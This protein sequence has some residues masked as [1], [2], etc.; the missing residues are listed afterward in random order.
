M[1]RGQVTHPR[2]V[3]R[4]QVFVSEAAERDIAESFKWYRA[5]SAAAAEVFRSEVIAAIDR[6]ANAPEAWRTDDDG[7]RRVVLR[8]F[9]YTVVYEI[10]DVSITILAV[11]HHR[12]RPGYWLRGTE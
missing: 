6:I 5:R 7:N 1:G 8:R 3:S 4:F 10:A 11:A 12:K 9:P 2:T